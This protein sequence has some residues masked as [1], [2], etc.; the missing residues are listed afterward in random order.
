MAAWPFLWLEQPGDPGRLDHEVRRQWPVRYGQLFPD[1]VGIT[2]QVLQGTPHHAF[3]QI[4][5]V[6]TS[7]YKTA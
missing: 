5:L 7:L 1:L 4:R 2:P 6:I 3:S